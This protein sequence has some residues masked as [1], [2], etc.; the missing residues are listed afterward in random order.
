MARRTASGLAH[1]CA[2]AAERRRRMIRAL[3]YASV[4]IVAALVSVL[5]MR[6]VRALGAGLGRLAYALDAGHRRI[7][8]ANLESAFPLRTAQERRAL[9]RAM[10]AHFGSLLLE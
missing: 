1:A 6:A 10:F 9:G 3:E 4:R 8:L 5:P 2:E 7:A